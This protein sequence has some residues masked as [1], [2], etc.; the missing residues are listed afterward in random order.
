MTSALR[1]DRQ[2]ED[3]ETRVHW[4][5]SG[6]VGLTVL[7]IATA[8][9]TF[10]VL[11]FDVLALPGRIVMDV[12]MATLLILGASATTRSRATM[13][14]VIGLVVLT[15]MT[16]IMDRVWPTPFMSRASTLMSMLTLFV[17]VGIV[18]MIT[19]RKGPMNWYRIQ[20]GI[21]A[22]MLLGLAWAAAFDFVEEIQPGSFRFVSAPQTADQLTL[23]LTYFSFSTLT[24][25][26][27]GDV[28]PI[29]P[30]ARSLTIAEAIVG[31]LFPAIL[32]A[33]LVAMALQSQSK[34]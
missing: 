27:L 26:G 10:V 30:A 29:L 7:T 28:T 21:C 2:H 19:F 33:V 32:V 22:Y 23:K 15:A 34:K 8:L 14:A 1:N 18:L 25:M 13:S 6:H 3:Y 4:L 17:Y 12:L 24:T 20:G 16:L 31:Q 9:I 11:P 5:W